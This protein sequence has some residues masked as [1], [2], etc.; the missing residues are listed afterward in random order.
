[1]SSVTSKVRRTLLVMLYHGGMGHFG[2]RK[3]LEILH[4]HFFWPRMR[5]DVTQICGRCI[6]CHKAKSKVLPHWLYTPDTNQGAGHADHTRENGAEVA[7]DPL[8]LPSA[9]NYKN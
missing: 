7:Q 6:T 5:R 3:T 8:S 4:E 1:M 2:V 9:G